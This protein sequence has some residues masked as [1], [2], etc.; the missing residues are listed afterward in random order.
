MMAELFSIQTLELEGETQP[1]VSARELHQRLEM[2][3]QF[4]NWF[5][6]QAERLELKEGIDF[7][8]FNV[9]VKNP[10]GGR[11]GGDYA[12]TL[13]AAKLIAMRSET[14]LANRICRY[15]IEVEKKWRR[16][17]KA[18]AAIDYTWVGTRQAARELG[19]HHNSLCSRIRVHGLLKRQG[20]HGVLVALE[21]VAAHLKEHPLRPLPGRLGS[22]SQKGG[23]MVITTAMLQALFKTYGAEG[24]QLVLHNM[25]RR[26]PH[27]NEVAALKAEVSR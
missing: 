10:K 13:D 20:P 19:V 5:P 12:L 21:V 22:K 2:K 24:T 14:K 3:R 25:D 26:Y 8:V 6:E 27:P 9:N 17:E 18:A 1:G 7:E 16:G 15:L 23:P 4:G 11:P